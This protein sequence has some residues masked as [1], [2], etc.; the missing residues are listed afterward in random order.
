M[1]PKRYNVSIYDA[2]NAYLECGT[3]VKAAEKLGIS[4]VAAQLRIARFEAKY[5]Q[6]II[7]TGRPRGAKPPSTRNSEIIKLYRTNPTTLTEI[8]ITYNLSRERVR[9]IIAREEGRQKL[10][11]QRNPKYR[12]P[13][14][15]M[16]DRTCPNCGKAFTTRAAN[17]TKYCSKKCFHQTHTKPIP[18]LEKMWEEYQ[19]GATYQDLMHKYGYWQTA[20]HKKFKQAGYKGRPKGSKPQKAADRAV[21]LA[22]SIKSM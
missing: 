4:P 12:G 16:L 19:A 8:G 5:D 7:N 17:P 9:Q 13:K 22:G 18:E 14:M 20:I 21:S 1:A 6:S 10:P 2:V 3:I 11:K 15:K